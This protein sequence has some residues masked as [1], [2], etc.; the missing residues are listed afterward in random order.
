MMQAAARTRKSRSTMEQR[1]QVYAALKAQPNGTL[2]AESL[3]EACD[4]LGL[5]MSVTNFKSAM[6]HLVHPRAHEGE[7]KLVSHH[8][9]WYGHARNIRPQHVWKAL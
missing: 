6:G 9:G 3:S 5:D 8:R 7:R 2:E 1:Q 4:L